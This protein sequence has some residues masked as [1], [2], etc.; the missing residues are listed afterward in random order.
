M[1]ANASRG[2]KVSILRLPLVIGENAPG[3]FGFLEK[4]AKTN[5]PLP[6]GLATNKRSVISVETVANLII[7]ATQSLAAFEGLHLLAES[8][9]VSTKELILGLRKKYSKSA[10]LIPVPKI[11]MKLVLNAIGKRKIYEQL[12]EDL[13]FKTSVNVTNFIKP[14]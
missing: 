3:N 6:F 4:I 12:Y 7:E 13:I 11:M 8:P 5:L 9:P 2:L 1:L 14:N 10:N